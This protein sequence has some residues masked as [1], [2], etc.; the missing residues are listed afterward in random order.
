MNIG[1]P[2]NDELYERLSARAKKDERSMA[3]EIRYLLAYALEAI[4]TDEKFQEAKKG[5][6]KQIAS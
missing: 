6:Q 4:E 1:I 3:G 5:V 2:V